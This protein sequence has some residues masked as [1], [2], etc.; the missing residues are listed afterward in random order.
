M[1]NRHRSANYCDGFES[2][3]SEHHGPRNLS[4]GR[5]QSARSTRSAAVNP[6]IV[7]RAVVAARQNRQSEAVEGLN[8]QSAIYAL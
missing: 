8:I 1:R 3:R 7:G 4:G 6:E 5:N 2:S